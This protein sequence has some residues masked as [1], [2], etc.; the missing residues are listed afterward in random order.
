MTAATEAVRAERK[1]LGWSVR[2]A[3]GRT[4]PEKE[5]RISNTYWGEFEDGKR[6]LTPQ[7]ERAVAVAFGWEQ[8]WASSPSPGGDV[9][10]Q[11]R[12]LRRAVLVLAEH[13]HLDIAHLL[14]G[15]PDQTSVGQ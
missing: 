1:R 3:A 11:I 4:G 14:D 2:E 7:I 15:S 9:Q 10:R 5:N 13:V 6:A 8:D 12:Q